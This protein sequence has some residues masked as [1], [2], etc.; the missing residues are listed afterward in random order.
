[1]RH[2][3]LQNC[4]LLWD[5]TCCRIFLFILG[6]IIEYALFIL[7][8]NRNGQDEFVLEL[9]N[10]FFYYF[11]QIDLESIFSLNPDLAPDEDIEPSP[12]TQ[13][14]PAPSAKVNKIVKVGKIYSYD[15]AELI[16]VLLCLNF[17]I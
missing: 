7:K 1:M 13:P 2:F 15:S 5:K 12:E 8:H 10:I 14:L 3:Q 9:I 4:G 16:N 6:Y 11:K 17:Y